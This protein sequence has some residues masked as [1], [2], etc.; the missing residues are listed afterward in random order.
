MEAM[1]T[2]DYPWDDMH[3]RA[4]FLPYLES[5]TLNTSSTPIEY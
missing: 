3:H 4:Y 1:S 2:P 5:T